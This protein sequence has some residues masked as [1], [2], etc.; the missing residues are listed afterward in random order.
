MDHDSVAR[1]LI[2]A[3]TGDEDGRAGVFLELVE[4]VSAPGL[5]FISRAL[6]VEAH[7]A[8][9]ELRVVLP[10]GVPWVELPPYEEIRAIECAALLAWGRYM[11]V[12]IIDAGQHAI[13]SPLQ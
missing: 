6:A 2:S 1:N 5:A 8:E 4:R 9:G 13:S 11:K 3:F 7:P 10:V 12:R